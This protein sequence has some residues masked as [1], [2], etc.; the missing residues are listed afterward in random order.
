MNDQPTKKRVVFQLIKS[1]FWG[2]LALAFAF[3]FVLYYTGNPYGEYLLITNGTTVDGKITAADEF[4]DDDERGR[5]VFSHTYA[6][7]FTLPDGKEVKSSGHGSGRLPAEYVNIKEPQPIKIV[8]LT[9]N[10]DINR[11]KAT[12]C[13]TLFELLWRKVGLGTLLLLMSSSVGFVI[14]KEGVRDYVKA[15]KMLFDG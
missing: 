5:A 8:Y 7:S 12:L 15:R 13:N 11:V 2:L 14:I 10:P 9:H 4:A 6:Y 3:W 1:L